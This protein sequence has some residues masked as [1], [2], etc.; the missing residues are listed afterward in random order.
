MIADVG[1]VCKGLGINV[2]RI[3]ARPLEDNKGVITAE[4][5]VRDIEQLN[6]LMRNLEKIEGVIGVER[7]R[8]L[9]QG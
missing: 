1:I 2:G 3:E 8:A 5:E 7:V 4:V 6:K 9:P